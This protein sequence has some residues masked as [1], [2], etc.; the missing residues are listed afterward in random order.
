MTSTPADFC[1]VVWEQVM[2]MACVDVVMQAT[3]ITSA[4][5]QSPEQMAEVFRLPRAVIAEA[6]DFTERYAAACL[7][8]RRDV[9]SL[10]IPDPWDAPRRA[11]SEKRV[12]QA[13]GRIAQL[14]ERNWA[15]RH[16]TALVSASNA[17][18]TLLCELA[19]RWEQGQRAYHQALQRCNATIPPSTG[20]VTTAKA[21]EKRPRK[22]GDTTDERLAAL[23]SSPDGVKQILAA[24]NSTGVGKLIGRCRSAVVSSVVW[25]TK[26]KPLFDTLKTDAKYQRLEFEDRRQDRRSDRRRK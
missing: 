22:R 9:P 12:T 21:K 1:E 14:A 13:I 20:K 19:S 11:S 3:A 16:P 7:E 24:G 26:I 15:L 8:A 5:P 6:V 4:P 23:R 17:R 10:P 2:D 25:K 18:T